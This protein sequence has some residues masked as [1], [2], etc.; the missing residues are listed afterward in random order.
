MNDWVGWRMIDWNWTERNTCLFFH[1]WILILVILICF[2]NWP[3]TTN[4]FIF[5]WTSICSFSP[6]SPYYFTSSFSLWRLQSLKDIAWFCLIFNK[7][8]TMC[9]TSRT[10]SWNNVTEC[11]NGTLCCTLIFQENEH[12]LL[13]NCC[14][15]QNWGW[16]NFINQL[17][18]MN[19][20]MKYSS[21]SWYHKK[22]TINLI[23]HW[24]DNVKL[25]L[26]W[27]L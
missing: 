17:K 13:S 8:M 27:T 7:Y 15:L 1:H 24:C 22:M 23:V 5:Y 4:P 19:L 18:E 12:A 14:L 6:L 16:E 2:T 26:A 9:I 11:M 20:K 3:L 25:F 10:N 21:L